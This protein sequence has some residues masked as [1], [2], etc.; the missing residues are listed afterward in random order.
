MLKLFYNQLTDLPQSDKNG[1]PD[2]E[3]VQLISSVR[4]QYIDSVMGHG[5]PSKLSTER[6]RI[7]VGIKF[8]LGIG[9]CNCGNGV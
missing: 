2:L 7:L 4:R 8:R 3:A 1:P 6:W 9:E 5:V